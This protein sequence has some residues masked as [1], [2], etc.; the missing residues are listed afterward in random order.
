[1]KKTVIALLLVVAML[2]AMPAFAEKAEGW[3]NVNVEG[4]QYPDYSGKTLS[5]MW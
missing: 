5:L 4:Y 3:N 1:M 2:C